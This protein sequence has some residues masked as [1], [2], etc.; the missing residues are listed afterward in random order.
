MNLTGSA[1]HK[2]TGGT[3]CWRHASWPALSQR[4]RRPAWFLGILTGLLTYP[5]R[6]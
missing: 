3:P 4:A 6:L 2:R 1:A 5:A